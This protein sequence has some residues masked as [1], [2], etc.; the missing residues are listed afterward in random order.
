MI[1]LGECSHPNLVKLIGYCCEN[2]H[3]VLVYEYMA[4]GSVENNLFS[5][6]YY[7]IPSYSFLDIENYI[8]F[9]FGYLSRSDND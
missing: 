7:N 8:L 3:R 6:K 1:F 9:I 4:R 2:E 5:S